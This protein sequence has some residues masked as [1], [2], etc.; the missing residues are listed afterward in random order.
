[1]NLDLSKSSDPDCIPVLVLKN[2]E[3][4]LSYILAELFHMC[5]LES[6]FL[7]C[8]KG[9]LVV[10]VLKNVQE[11]S[12]A[13]NYCPVSLLPVV[14]KVFKKLVKNRILDQLEKYGL[15]SS[16]STTDLLTVV[17]EFRALRLLTGFGMFGSFGQ[18]WL[19]V[20]LNGKASQEYPVNAGVPQGSILGPTFFPLYIYVLPDDVICDI[21]IYADDTTLFSAT[22]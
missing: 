5:L 2:C 13:K 20:V 3:P 17:P 21:A 1:M 4:E 8:W 22:T 6:C 15:C 14:S 16:R 19:R 18:G 9:L 10:L 11:R 7:D 12:I